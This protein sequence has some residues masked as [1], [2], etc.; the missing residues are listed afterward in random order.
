[1]KHRRSTRVGIKG[2]RRRTAWCLGRAQNEPKDLVV[3][4][5]KHRL[6]ALLLGMEEDLGSGMA[7]RG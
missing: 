7:L 4:F 2:Q 1:M 6:P 5:M 3:G